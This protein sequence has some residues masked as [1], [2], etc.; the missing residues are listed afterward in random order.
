M[1]SRKKTNDGRAVFNEDE[2]TFIR[3]ELC[4]ENTS[5]IH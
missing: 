3:K 1:G 2:A 5:V 4:T